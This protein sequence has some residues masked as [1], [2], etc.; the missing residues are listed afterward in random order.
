MGALDVELAGLQARLVTDPANKERVERRI[1][2]V[3]A[4]IK[5]ATAAAAAV[6]QIEAAVAMEVETATLPKPKR[7]K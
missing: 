5:A 2:E 6:P 3:K 7:N 1:G 4:A